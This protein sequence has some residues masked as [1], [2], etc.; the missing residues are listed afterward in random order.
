MILITGGAGFIGSHI[1]DVLTKNNYKT[2]IADNLSTG[3]KENINSDSIFYNADIKNYNDI[4]YIFYKHNIEYIL[5][6]F[7]FVN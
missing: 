2:I 1:A 3:K 5:E 7:H 6:L 4:E